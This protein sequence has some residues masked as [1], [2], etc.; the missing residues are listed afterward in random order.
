MKKIMFLALLA[1]IGNL[2]F[3]A[4]AGPTLKTGT[5]R[6]VMA[7]PGGDL[8]FKLVVEGEDKGFKATGYN[9]SEMVVFDRVT[10]DEK[11]KVTFTIEHYEST[12]TAML[13]ASGER[14][15]GTW[16]KVTGKD[17]KAK[18]PFH[19]EYDQPIRFVAK[20]VDKPVNL[21]GRWA[22]T[23]ANGDD[24]PEDAVAEFVQKGSHLSGTFLTPTGDYRFLE[25]IV[26]GRDLLLSCFD[27]GHAFLFK[28]TLNQ[29]DQLEG[30]FYSRD[31]WHDTWTAV[32]DEDAALPDPYHMTTLKKGLDHFSFRFPDLEGNP[33]SD[34]D[35][36]LEGKVLLITIFGSWCPNCN[37]EADMLAE[38]YRDYHKRGLEIVGLA[39]EMTDNTDRNRRVLKRFAERHGADYRILLAGTATDKRKAAE[40]L[41]NLNHVLSYPTSILI[42]RSGKVRSI[43]TGFTGPGTGQ[44]YLD[45]VKRYRQRIEDLL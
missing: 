39:F 41:G 7:S 42:D 5:W 10:V 14:M 8:P 44:H 28:A 6:V 21:G 31:S 32:R 30:H 23:F 16:T 29:S 38:F 25:G 27:G 45:L 36:D 2:I 18:L 20:S 11:G 34:K 33:V 13:D 3:L 26:D 43:H 1:L 15:E 35:A 9:G 40:A 37:D 22:V 4:L 19:A 17:K 12:F 24:E